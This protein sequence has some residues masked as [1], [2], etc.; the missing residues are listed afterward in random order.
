MKYVNTSTL[1]NVMKC[2]EIPLI[3]VIEFLSSLQHILMLQKQVTGLGTAVVILI[4]L[5]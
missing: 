5:Q 3:H 1:S 2:Y 4:Q